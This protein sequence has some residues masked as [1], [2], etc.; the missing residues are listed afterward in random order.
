M[1]A[2]AGL[3]PR[4]RDTGDRLPQGR[5]PPPVVGLFHQ[6]ACRCPKTS[7]SAG[8]SAWSCARGGCVGRARAGAHWSRTKSID[9][10]G[11]GRAGDSKLV[12]PVG[13]GSVELPSSR[14]NVGGTQDFAAGKTELAKMSNNWHKPS[15]EQTP[16]RTRPANRGTTIADRQRL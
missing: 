3:M 11:A 10:P 2:D 15:S 16:R 13:S 7:R 5:A 9:V 14:D 1:A 4:P 8:P 12:D 6:P